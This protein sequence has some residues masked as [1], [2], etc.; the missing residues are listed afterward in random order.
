[1]ACMWVEE[2]EEARK[3]FGENLVE[4]T[5]FLPRLQIPEQHGCQSSQGQVLHWSRRVVQVWK[6]RRG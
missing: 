5:Q 4:K 2:E 3:K 6:R 1:M